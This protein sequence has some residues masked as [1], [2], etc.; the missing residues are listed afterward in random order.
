MNWLEAHGRRDGAEQPA[1]SHARLRPSSQ[2]RSW[3]SSGL[4]PAQEHRYLLTA[5]PGE[6]VARVIPTHPARAQ[7]GDRPIGHRGHVK[8]AGYR[9][10]V[11]EPHHTPCVRIRG[12]CPATC[13]HPTSNHQQPPVTGPHKQKELAMPAI[14]HHKITVEG[15]GVF[16]REAGDPARPSIVLLPGYPSSTRAY[17]RL[18]DRLAHDWHAVAIDY[19]GFGSSHPLPDTRPS[20]ASRKS[21]ARP[22]TSSASATM[23]STCSTS[24]HRSGSASPLSTTSGSAPSSPRTATP[25]PTG[26]APAFKASPTSG[27]TALPGSRPSTGSSAGGTQ[28]QWQAGARD[29]EHIDPEQAL[30]TRPSS[31]GPAGQTT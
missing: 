24:A 18:V 9:I 22:S 20:T 21:P 13:L 12:V 5:D 31:T 19:P 26:S 29:P 4:P 11:R 17:V 1:H 3:P 25:T 15:R 16:V 23:P 6:L 14:R 28:L 30:A 7:G 10:A 8:P 27:R 2:G